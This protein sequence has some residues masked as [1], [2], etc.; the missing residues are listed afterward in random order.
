[1]DLLTLAGSLL[2]T[3]FGFLVLNMLLAPPRLYQETDPDLRLQIIADY[4]ARWIAAQVF[5]GMAPLI[6]AIGFLLLAIHFQDAQFPLLL[7][8]GAAALILGAASMMIYTFQAVAD[9]GP[10]LT[11]TKP[12]PLVIA[13]VVL[14]SIGGILFGVFFTQSTIPNWLGYLT[15]GSAALL[16]AYLLIRESIGYISIMLFYLI[17]LILGIV[18]VL[19]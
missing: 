7:N 14:T 11:S 13:G 16:L 5:G 19:Q 9:P 18:L 17:T 4:R 8:I 3:G 2:I 15:I 6:T 10:Y 1:M 12:S